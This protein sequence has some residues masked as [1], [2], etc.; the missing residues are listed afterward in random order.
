MRVHRQQTEPWQAIARRLELKH[1][2]RWS[3]S[4]PRMVDHDVDGDD[5]VLFGGCAGGG[6]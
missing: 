2:E 5:D 1:P 3:L 4:P 6:P